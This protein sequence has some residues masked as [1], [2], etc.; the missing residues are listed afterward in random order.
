MSLTILV[1]KAD[2]KILLGGKRVGTLPTA[3]RLVFYFNLWMRPNIGLLKDFWMHISLKFPMPWGTRQFT[4][5]INL[6]TSWDKSSVLNF[7]R[8]LYQKCYQY[9]FI[10]RKEPMIIFSTSPAAIKNSSAKISEL[11]SASIWSPGFHFGSRSSSK[12]FKVWN[13]ACGTHTT[14]LHRLFRVRV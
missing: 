11:L 8:L 2:C 13:M 4:L 3:C 5:L 10:C 14:P 9:M 7:L 12:D 1:A 6:P